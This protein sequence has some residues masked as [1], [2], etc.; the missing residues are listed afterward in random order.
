MAE[1]GCD[2]SSITLKKCAGSQECKTALM[3]LKAGRLQEDFIE[4]MMCPGGCVG[5]P[6][7][8]KAENEII[9]A[10][11]G[12]LKKA[13]NRHVMDNIKNYPMDSFS[14]YRDGHMEPE[15]DPDIERK[16]Q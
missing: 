16:E 13:D 15:H 12:L 5:G 1:R 4:G 2:T 8:H 10:R 3:L 14:M 6:S 9:K 7:K 11:E